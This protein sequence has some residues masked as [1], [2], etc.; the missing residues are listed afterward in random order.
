M[1]G[2]DSTSV[3][4]PPIFLKPVLG[5]ASIP[6]APKTLPE[7]IIRQ[8]SEISLRSNSRSNVKMLSKFFH[9]HYGV[10]RRK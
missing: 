4:F 5:L 9:F 7:L 3:E 2:G 1:T 6:F 8:L 10:S